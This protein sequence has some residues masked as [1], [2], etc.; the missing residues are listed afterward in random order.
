MNYK[1]NSATKWKNSFEWH[2]WFA[3]HPVSINGDEIV[4]LIWVERKREITWW[5]HWWN[6]RLIKTLDTNL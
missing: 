1:H 2:R 6:Y 4:W 3:W 5:E